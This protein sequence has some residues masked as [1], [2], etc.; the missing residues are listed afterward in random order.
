MP[1][2]KREGIY[3]GLMMV[4]S[5]VFVMFFYNMYREG[6]LSTLTVS[7]ALLHFALTFIVAFLLESFIVG[8]IARGIAFKLPYDKSKKV[9]VI[10][11]VS[12]CM[13]TGM[14]ICM[15][16][17]GLITALL[18]NSL[19]G[20]LLKNYFMLFIQNFVV[21][22]PVQL[23][24]VGPLARWILVKFIKKNSIQPKFEYN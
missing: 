13:V 9:Y 8:P 2:N 5:M 10:I 3:F 6:L 24:V 18:S 23:L 19:E 4:F 17:F 1:S 20:P 22:Y 7:S 14:V 16:V 11:A 15:S 21:A 12:T